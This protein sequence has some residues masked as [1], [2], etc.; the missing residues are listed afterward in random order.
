[1]SENRPK[2]RFFRPRKSLHAGDWAA[3]E[4][5]PSITPGPPPRG[6]ETVLLVEDE[7][8]VRRL[9][10]LSL[11]RH[12]YTVLEPTGGH[13]ALELADAYHG[14]IATLLTDVVMPGLNGH[15]LPERLL[16]CRPI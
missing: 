7:D 12:G 9:A 10:R 1:M 4:P 16:A 3:Q 8:G 5:R 14:P 15:E 13:A 11:E 2:R 6:S